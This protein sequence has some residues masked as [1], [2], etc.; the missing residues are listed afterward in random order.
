MFLS[1]TRG[2]VFYASLFA[3]CPAFY[4]IFR[5]PYPFGGHDAFSASIWFS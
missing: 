4:C 3:V 1:V 5:R 2:C